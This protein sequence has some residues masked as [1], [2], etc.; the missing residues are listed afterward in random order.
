MLVLTRLRVE[1][2]VVA[3]NDQ[4]KDVAYLVEHS[5]YQIDVIY[6]ETLRVSEFPNNLW[7]VEMES[8]LVSCWAEVSGFY[9][10]ALRSEDD[11]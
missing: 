1:T 8:A 7:L 6:F 11:P 3:Q 5:I 10:S 2:I 9:L 4:L